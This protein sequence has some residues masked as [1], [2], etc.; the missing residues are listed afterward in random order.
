MGRRRWTPAEDEV[1]RARY[2]VDPA[3]VIGQALGRSKSSIYIRA[4]ALGLKKPREAIAEC[5][6][7]RWKQGKHEASRPHQFQKGRAPANKGLRRPGYAPGR[8]AETQFKKGQ[9]HGA[10]QHNYVPIGTEKIDTKRGVLVRKMTDDPTMY[11]A[12][13]WRPVHT[14]VWES[15]HGPVPEGHLVI[16]R[17]GMKTYN[18]GEITVDKLELVTR[19]ENMRRNTL[20]R[21]P[22]E[23]KDAMRL[24]GRIKRQ[25]RKDD[26]E[27]QH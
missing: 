10:A 22:Q 24:I 13:R 23:I 4:H 9:M 20:H 27:E 5:T 25:M 26:V 12:R 7:Q 6:R 11:P 16:F 3:H 2:G 15:V 14:M 19:T 1:L 17:R 18:A 8:M 21:Y